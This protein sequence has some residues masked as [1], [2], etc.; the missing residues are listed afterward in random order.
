MNQESLFPTIDVE[1]KH[2]LFIIGN[3]FDIAHRLKT[4]YCDFKEW[5]RQ[6]GN[7][8]LVR[9]TETFFS[10]YR[11]FW[12]DIEKALGEYDE[13]EI[14]DWCSPDEGID[15]EHPTRSVAAI[16]DG[17]DWLFKPILDEF[18]EAFNQW[19]ES[20]DINEAIVMFSL[21]AESHYLTFNYTE[22]LEKL[23]GIPQ[24]NI[25]HIHGSRLKH[26]D[27]IIGHNQK[28][29]PNDAYEDETE[30]L[31]KQDTW[32]KVI[33]WMNELVK[34]TN[35]IIKHNQAFFNSLGDITKV[36]VIGHSFYPVDYPYMIEV[37]QQTGTTVLWTISYHTQND[38]ERIKNFVNHTRLQ[39]YIFFEL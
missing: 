17:P 3:G 37:V 7:D 10:N 30:L 29:D 20:I 35:G 32:S 14:V 27:Y 25:L 2:T 19:V 16:E 38:I 23:Y 13:E 31:F 28:R 26:D 18:L 15:Y 36:V 22:T 8:H 4:Q 24:E 6:Q 1:N 5:L 9:M 39:N 11:D 34:D 33:A 21:P 12:G